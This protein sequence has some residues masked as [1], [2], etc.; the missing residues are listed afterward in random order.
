MELKNIYRGMENGAE[1]IES[2]FSTIES[3][4][5]EMDSK[6][7]GYFTAKS[8]PN[9]KLVVEL[10]WE[11]VKSSED[12]YLSDNK[13]I[14]TKAGFY[15]L[16]GQISLYNQ[17]DDEWKSLHFEIS[18]NGS[19]SNTIEV[20]RTYPKNSSVSPIAL[21]ELQSGAQIRAVKNGASTSGSIIRSA[22]TI[23]KIA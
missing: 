8:T 12:I 9:D 1:A 13:V 6:S 3:S 21:V 5:A 14:V 11:K 4:V 16:A 19:I 22:M 20:L 17:T 7:F 2:N 15:H 10:P 23:V 18:N